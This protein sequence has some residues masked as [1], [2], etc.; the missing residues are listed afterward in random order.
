MAD[1][2]RSP[3]FTV[4]GQLDAAA[5]STGSIRARG[6]ILTRAADRAAASSDGD[7]KCAHEG[8]LHRA[9]RK[10]P[11]TVQRQSSASA[12][13]GRGPNRARVPRRR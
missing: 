8:R 3:H 13:A 7:F 12:N 11:P 1:I 6:V 10:E 5:F 9:R 4:E 2:R